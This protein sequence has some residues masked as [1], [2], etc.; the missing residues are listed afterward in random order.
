M[1]T[2]TRYNERYV[3]RPSDGYDGVGEV[4]VGDVLGSGTLLA[5]GRAVLTAAHVVEGATDP[6]RVAFDGLGGRYWA[7]AET[8]WVHPGYDPGAFGNDL[9][10]L[11]LDNPVPD[12]IPR[13]ALY[14]GADELGHVATLVGYGATGLGQWGYSGPAGAQRSRVENTLD[15]T[16]S[17]VSSRLNGGGWDSP[18]GS[19]LI[20]DFDSGE[21]RY[22]TL[23]RLLGQS[24]TGLGTTEGV[25]APGDSGG[26]A[27]IDGRVAG[28]ASY[29][30]H[31]A[32][33]RGQ[34]LDST[35]GVDGSFGE[36]AAWQRVSHY[37]DWIDATLATVGS[38]LTAS[39][40]EAPALGGTGERVTGGPGDDTLVGGDGNDRLTGGAGDD[41][42][43]GGGG[44]DIVRFD[45]TADT[46]ALT[47]PSDGTLV[48]TEADGSRDTLENIELL[49]FDDRVV[50][51]SP[52]ELD[53][54]SSMPFDAG[55][56][57]ETNPDV[58][59][60]AAAGVI[61]P[62]AHYQ[63][64]GAG[65]GR[66]PNALF[67]ERGYRAAN[68]D[69]DAAIQRGDQDSGYQHYLTWGW[70]EGRAPSAWF[71]SRAYL[72]D[73]PDVAA[74]GVEPLGHYLQYGYSEGRVIVPDDEG[75]WG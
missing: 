32:D 7:T 57:L 23:G 63:Q 33:G 20:A 75:L 36:L 40:P 70:K 12:A 44:V 26:P 52:P 6:V 22:D 15:A 53:S 31:L 45:M 49:R 11:W 65:E 69:V 14:R 72:A 60:A 30:T 19:Q 9:A 10:L 64:Y 41:H 47:H 37:Q 39:T 25:I 71:D 48:V 66:D 42:L 54:A 61:G 67:D 3:S 46:V 55:L 13:Y 43:D 59:A 58:A 34:L 50:L 51:A 5:D 18:P 16:G 56:Y 38:S 35:L 73:N 68:P 29:L 1:P 28:V 21:A 2:V 62:L 24:D 4:R 8:R 27:F 74:A 17:E